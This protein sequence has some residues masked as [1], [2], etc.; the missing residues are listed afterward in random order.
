MLPPPMARSGSTGRSPLI[1]RK[2][3]P[4]GVVIT[5]SSP[6][7]S[8]RNLTRLQ[9]GRQLLGPEARDSY[10]ATSLV[11]QSV[12]PAFR[13]TTKIVRDV[14]MAVVGQYMHEPR[15]TFEEMK[16]RRMQ[17][18]AVPAQLPAISN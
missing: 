8:T 16:A 10:V 13:S 12:L 18:P 15:P 2:S 4:V 11:N 3:G 1:P 6:L 14:M 7:R 17:F 5:H 9:A